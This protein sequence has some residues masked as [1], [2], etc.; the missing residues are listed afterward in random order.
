M[1]KVD[2]IKEYLNINFGYLYFIYILF[3]FYRFE[4]FYEVLKF[5][6][7]IN[8]DLEIDDENGW[9]LLIL[10]VSNFLEENI[11]NKENINE[12]L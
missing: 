2:S 6:F 1:F 3:V 5:N 8:L 7:E 11:D 10:V 12:L 9:M 4:L